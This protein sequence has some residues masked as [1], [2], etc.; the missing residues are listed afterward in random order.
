MHLIGESSTA[1]DKLM[2]NFVLKST[3]QDLKCVLTWISWIWVWDSDCGWCCCCW[4]GWLVGCYCCPRC[5]SRTFHCSGHRNSV[6]GNGRRLK[7]FTFTQRWW[8]LISWTD[9]LETGII[10][11]HKH[12]MAVT[13]PGHLIIIVD[14]WSE[15][16]EGVWIS[17]Q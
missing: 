8:A 15:R 1:V 5:L 14:W 16:A 17:G 7:C 9:I 11:W 6:N 12:E 13:H 4:F 2:P 10:W 3:H